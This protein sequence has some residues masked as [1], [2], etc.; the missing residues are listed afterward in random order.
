VIVTGL[1]ERVVVQNAATT[2]RDSHGNP[3]LN[4]QAP[5]TAAE[6]AFVAPLSTTELVAGQDVVISRYR[7]LLHPRTAAKATSRILWRGGIFEVDGDVS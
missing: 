3:V 7:I 4:W 1:P 5:A 6:R 2:G